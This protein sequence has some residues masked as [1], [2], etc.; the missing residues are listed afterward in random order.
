[1][2]RGLINLRENPHT[3]ETMSNMFDFD[4]EISDIEK[5]L[6]SVKEKIEP[7]FNLLMYFF[8]YLMVRLMTLLFS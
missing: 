4:L 6:F 2:T 3:T 1:M 5:D 8:N 7:I